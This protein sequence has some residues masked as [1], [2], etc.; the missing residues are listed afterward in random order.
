MQV[1]RP[2]VRF[3]GRQTAAGVTPEPE[4]RVPGA[5][6][7]LGSRERCCERLQPHL[8]LPEAVSQPLRERDYSQR[9]RKGNSD[10]LA[11][12]SYKAGLFLPLTLSFL[13]VGV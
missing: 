5:H 10:A 6:S 12:F 7:Q 3:A 2:G 8:P 11:L 9:G 1:A 4:H 13:S